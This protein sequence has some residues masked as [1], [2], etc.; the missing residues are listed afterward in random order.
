MVW[1]HVGVS[2]QRPSSMRHF[3]PDSQC[4]LES[5]PFRQKVCRLLARNFLGIGKLAAR[6]NR[7]INSLVFGSLLHHTTTETLKIQTLTMSLTSLNVDVLLH[8]M[9]F[10]KPVDRFNLVLSGILKGF[11]NVN[12]G[13]DLRKRYSKHFN[14]VSSCSQTVFCPESTVVEL[15]WGYVVVARAN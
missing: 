1:L 14:F 10:L 2:D 12:K 15:N 7:S 6:F 8:L 5:E 9:K 11:E 13:I 3:V 4:L